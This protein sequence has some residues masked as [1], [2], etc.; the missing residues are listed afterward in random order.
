MP[1]RIRKALDNFTTDYIYI[2]P[3]LEENF[4]KIMI[5]LPRS[6]FRNLDSHMKRRG[7]D[8]FR[9][10]GLSLLKLLA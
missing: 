9:V 8:S 5:F 4:P 6:A 1:P 2:A 3:T 10:C 7:L